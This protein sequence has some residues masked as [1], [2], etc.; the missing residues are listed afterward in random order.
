MKLRDYWKYAGTPGKVFMTIVVMLVALAIAQAITVGMAHS[1]HKPT[2]PPDKELTEEEKRVSRIRNSAKQCL[3]DGTIHLVHQPGRRSYSQ[4]EESGKQQIYDTNDNLLW[5]GIAKDSPY[6]YLSW[7]VAARNYSFA[8]ATMRQMQMITPELSQTL[9]VRVKSQDKTIEVWRYIPNGDCFIGYKAGGEKI[10]YLGST[11]F[12][13]SRSEAKPLGE[14]DLF[15]AWSPQD[16]VSPS[17]LWQT[18]RRIYEIN[19]EKRK[20]ELI[21]ESPDS[22]ID[23]LFVHTWDSYR[24]QEV[25]PAKGYRSLLCCQTKD[26]ENHLI[27]RDPA[28]QLTVKTPEDWDKWCGNYVRFAAV[29]QG[30][31]LHRQ[32]VEFKKP[33]DYFRQ[34]QLAEQWRRD[35]QAK[36]KKNHAEFY[37]VDDQGDIELLNRYAWTVPGET[38]DKQQWVYV[39]ETIQYS[40]NQV[41]PPLY[42]LFL[43]VYM[44]SA[45]WPIDWRNRT[46]TYE[47]LTAMGYLTPGATAWN[48]ILGLLMVGFAYWHGR[49]RW[50]R[51]AELIFWL[52]FVWLFNLA[53]LLTYLALNHTPVIKCPL[54]GQRRG[55][56]QVN[57]VRCEG[58]LPA[59]KPGELDL[60]SDIQPG[61]AG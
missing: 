27:M 7:T 55:L 51:R 53:G 47:I 1:F 32:W 58:P 52:V 60:I 33:P 23:R 34:K 19:F 22:A 36:P 9:D 57:C 13:E 8:A 31:F 39:W 41:S 5:E 4:W 30:V 24:P 38:K 11:G 54:C 28:Q 40:V 20:A 26:R 56:A 25:K 59:P 44:R 49:P 35:Y 18:S 17:L 6:K 61:A 45:E 15:L 16:S 2:T 46:A 48:W 50:T 42:D 37:K 21:F 14:F 12:A 10:G 3:P 43:Y 29:E